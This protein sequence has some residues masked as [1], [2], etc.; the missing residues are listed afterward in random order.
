MKAVPS[1]DFFLK[2]SPLAEA[3]EDYIVEEVVLGNV[4]DL[5][6]PLS[7]DPLHESPPL[8]GPLNLWRHSGLRMQNPQQDMTIL[9]P[10]GDLLNQM[11]KNLEKVLLKVVEKGLVGPDQQ[12]PRGRINLLAL[13]A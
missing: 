8:S 2:E 9:P 6:L 11:L 4:E 13:G 7:E 5:V 1:Q 12:G 10:I 3:E